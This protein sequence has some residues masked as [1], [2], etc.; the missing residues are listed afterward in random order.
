MRK[1]TS[2]PTLKSP[3]GVLPW[4]ITV[5]SHWLKINCYIKF[6]L[7]S[8]LIP[9]TSSISVLVLLGL[10]GKQ[11]I[12]S[13]YQTI[14]TSQIFWLPKNCPPPNILTPNKYDYPIIRKWLQRKDSE[15][16]KRK[17]KKKS[18]ALK[19]LFH[20]KYQIIKNIPLC[21]K[22]QVIQIRKGK[23]IVSSCNQR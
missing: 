5:L 1:Y 13:Q 21:L 2:K 15:Y 14:K 6:M 11:P 17:T 9:P 12:H 8:S 4:S 19:I 22:S 20:T 23:S 18:L 16:G 10:Q 7:L 3:G